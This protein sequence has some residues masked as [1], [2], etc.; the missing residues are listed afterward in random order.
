MRK[1]LAL[2]VMLSALCVLVGPPVVTAGEGP[3]RDREAEDW[4]RNFSRPEKESI[5]LGDC[6]WECS[7][8]T[9]GGCDAPSGSI[10]LDECWNACGGIL[11]SN[12]NW[13]PPP[14]N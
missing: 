13:S 5:T 8:G 11:E 6:S 10:C 2:W 7:N 14:P 12:C 3:R 4:A 9:S 1:R